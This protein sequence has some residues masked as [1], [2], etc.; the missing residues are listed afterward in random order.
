MSQLILLI[1]RNHSDISGLQMTAASVL[2]PLFTKIKRGK[3]RGRKRRNRAGKRE[4]EGE[5]ED[6]IRNKGEKSR[7]EKE[8][9]IKAKGKGGETRD[10]TQ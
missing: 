5:S 9:V 7:G 6:R 3:E 10:P 2:H 8:K 1:E 4:Q